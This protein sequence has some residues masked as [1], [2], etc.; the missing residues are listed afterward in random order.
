MNI[1]RHRTYISL[2]RCDVSYSAKY[3]AMEDQFITIAK[4]NDKDGVSYKMNPAEKDC[5]DTFML[6]RNNSLLWGKSNVDKNGKAKIFDEDGQPI[7]S[8]DGLIPQ[9]ERFAGKYIFSK[10]NM[11]VFETALNAMVAKSEKPTGNQYMMICNTAFWTEAQRA[12]ANWIRD[13]R[14]NGAFV[15]S[16]GT[17]GYVD[18]GAT[19]NSYSFA[20]N[21]IMFKVDRSFDI[22]F[23]APTKFAIFVDLTA[24]SKTGREALSMFTFKGQQIVTN[25]LVG[26]GGRDGKS[27]GEVSTPVA[28]AKF[29]A[30]GYS[31]IAVFNPYRSFILMSE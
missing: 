2:H 13:Y 17:N 26:P 23:P 1:E 9:I 25:W 19:Y 11:R 3:R 20:G 27:G 10:L 15:Y 28:G 5:L 29:M 12:L 4:D 24:D 16:K 7:I 8:G 21:T 22:E 6:S 30:W 18:L 14:T 31:G